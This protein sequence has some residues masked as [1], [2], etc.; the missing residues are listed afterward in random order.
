MNYARA[1]VLIFVL[2]TTCSITSL[3]AQDLTPKEFVEQ[4]PVLPLPGQ[5]SDVPL[6]NSNNPEVVQSEG[7][8]LSTLSPQGKATPNAHL[9]Y[10]FQ[11]DFGIFSHHIARPFDDK[12]KR[13]LYQGLIL[14]NP[15]DVDA[16]VEVRSGASYLS[17]PDSPFI[18][19]PAQLPNPHGKIHAG[20]GGRV[21]D[22]V[23]RGRRPKSRL[24]KHEVTVSPKVAVV[25]ARLPIPV[26]KWNPPLNG[27]STL[28]H[29]SVKAGAVQAADVAVYGRFDSKGKE[30]KPENQEFIDVLNK[31]DLAG[32]RE[33]P[34]TA[35]GASGP[36]AYGRVAGVS[37]GTIWNSVATE[38]S[39][40]PEQKSFPIALP[41]EQFS[42]VVSALQHG[43]FGSGQDQAAP[44][45]VRYPETAYR[46]HGNYGVFYDLALTLENN[47][48]EAHDVDIIFQTPLKDDKKSAGLQF[49]SPP[50]KPVFFRGT[51]RVSYPDARGKLR[52]R[53]FHL[54][55]HRG[56]QGQP[57]ATVHILPGQSRNVVLQF[58][59][60][61]DAT[62]PHVLTFRT[63][64]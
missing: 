54:V 7:I 26:G 19:L 51:V 3:L 6:F 37:Q 48:E 43:S 57:L 46:A 17:Q 36:F 9:D 8:L 60:P 47:Q 4:Q 45:V 40:V 35:P 32:P 18:D 29:L 56:E 52:T 64:R 30:I 14:F 55:Q 28:L 58:V 12:D 2:V 42:F 63:L 62:P 13:T 59:Y 39:G 34:A 22:D 5:L 50:Y 16:K 38:A 41:G 49:A 27:R 31:G 33:K 44:L 53:H 15:G 25:I 23:L 24:I 10:L 21:S 11:G 20:P 1:A 61:P